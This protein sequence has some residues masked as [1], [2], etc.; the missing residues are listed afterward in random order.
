MAELRDAEP[1]RFDFGAA[2]R[3]AAQCRATAVDLRSEVSHRNVLA[4]GARKDWRGA[5]E[6]RF[7]ERMK[8]FARD[9][10]RIAV[11]M[12]KAAGQVVELARLAREE[13][14]RRT[15]A[16]EWKRQHDEWQRKKDQQSIAEDIVDWATGNDDGPEPP[17]LT[18]ARPPDLPV[19]AP[20]PG[21]RE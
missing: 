17:N 5:Y 19:E 4:D 13:Q 21:S 7:G 20:S 16:R 2:D 3:L 15:K 9:A 1:I 12:E 14:D 18:P 8:V 11:A 6:V 10:E